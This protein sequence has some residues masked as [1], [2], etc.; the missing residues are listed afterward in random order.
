MLRHGD[1]E[2]LIAVIDWETAA[3]G[4]SVYDLVSLTAGKWT[5]EQRRTL[6]RAYFDEYQAYAKLQLDWE[7]FYSSL[8]DVELYQALEWLGWWRNRSFSPYFGKWMKELE[9]V[10]SDFLPVV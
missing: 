3:V 2:K 7:S 8:H 1:Q 9:R 4:P 10:M 6:R 5:D